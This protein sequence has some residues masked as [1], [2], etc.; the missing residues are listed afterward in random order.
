MNNEINSIQMASLLA[1]VASFLATRFLIMACL[2]DEPNARK[3]HNEIK[4]NG[5]GIAIIIG[6]CSAIIYLQLNDNIFNDFQLYMALGIGLIV[7]AIG[8]IDDIY[9]LDAK[10]RLLLLFAIAIIIASTNLRVEQLHI[11]GGLILPLG[12]VFG[13]IGTMLWIISMINCVNFMD[14]A[15]GIAMGSMAISLYGLAFLTYWHGDLSIAILCFLAANSSLGFLVYNVIKGNIFAG[16]I[17]AYFIGFLYAIC[18]LFAIRAGVSP[19]LVSLCVLPFL[20]ETLGTIIYRKKIG[21]NILSPHNKHLYQLIIR[22]GKSHL[23][24][25]FLWW[26]MTLF[27]VLCAIFID[28]NFQNFS[29]A[30][31]LFL[32][33]LYF[34]G[35]YFARPILMKKL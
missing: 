5:G 12:M 18:G 10:I 35:A 2:N 1:F 20:C 33:L 19:F 16:D 21:D 8:L 15:N 17:G 4:A 13:A 23:Y 28:K 14:G 32:S 6:L 22:G 34:I 9:H 29:S 24:S 25:A 27:C 26:V 3:A 11:G 30:I 7:G 31:F